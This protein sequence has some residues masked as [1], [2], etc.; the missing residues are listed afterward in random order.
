MIVQLWESPIDERKTKRVV[1]IFGLGL[2]GSSISTSL[3]RRVSSQVIEFP[4]SWVCADKRSDQIRD[5]LL[6]L[7]KH[8]AGFKPYAEID[9]VWA[10]GKAGFGG[11]RDVF[12]S[13]QESFNSVLELIHGNDLSDYALVRLHLI[14]SAGGLFEGQRKV[15]GSSVINPLRPY[16]EAKVRIEDEVKKLNSSIVSHIYRPSSVYGYAGMNGRA[17]LVVAILN[18]VLRNTTAR[19]YAQPDTLRDYV[20]VSDIGRFVAQTIAFRTGPSQ[21]HFLASGKPTSTLEVI[22]LI[23]RVMQRRI[24]VQFELTADNTE[25]NTF[26]AA[27][28][29]DHWNPTTL[30]VGVNITALKIRHALQHS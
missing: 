15:D 20:Y 17:G 21:I 6:F 9:V 30:E 27:A 11:S 5:V 29:P 3:R 4:F 18:S 24:S 22:K 1:L 7:K 23:E 2:I 8:I 16:G 14:S 25:P 26:Q 10:A 28:R 19:I 12:E 13:E